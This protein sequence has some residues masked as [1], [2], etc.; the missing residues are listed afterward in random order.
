MEGRASRPSRRAGTLASPFFT[1]HVHQAARCTKWSAVVERDGHSVGRQIDG[2]LLPAVE[3]KLH[4]VRQRDA[5]ILR[6]VVN[7]HEYMLARTN[8]AADLDGVRRG[9]EQGRCGR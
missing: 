1:D 2:V 5:L 7:E 8:A 3:H 6:G 9:S 4:R